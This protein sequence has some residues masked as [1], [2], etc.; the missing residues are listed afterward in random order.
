[1][2]SVV[3]DLA[4]QT[5]VLGANE[6]VLSSGSGIAPPVLRGA[7]E[8][9]STMAGKSGRGFARMEPEKQREIAR[10]GGRAAHASGHAHEWDSQ[11]AAI[12]GRKGGLAAHHH[13]GAT[14]PKTGDHDGGARAEEGDG[15]EALHLEGGDKEISPPEEATVHAEGE[16]EGNIVAEV[17]YPESEGLEPGTDAHA[18]GDLGEQR[19]KGHRPRPMSH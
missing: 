16:G 19:T 12:A 18:H 14:Y 6:S 2:R 9:G 7:T 13:K 11:Q 4:D 5:A 8:G 3:A 15:R 1:L 10:A 17:E